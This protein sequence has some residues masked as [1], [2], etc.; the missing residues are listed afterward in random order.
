MW[1]PMGRLLHKLNAMRAHV[2]ATL[3][4]A[5]A[6]SGD[7]MPEVED[8]KGKRPRPT[9]FG[10][11]PPAAQVLPQQSPRGERSPSQPSVGYSE[12]SH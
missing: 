8:P 5:G 3:A 7:V 2:A 9:N 12:Y 1:T 4:E 11:P 6:E 10:S